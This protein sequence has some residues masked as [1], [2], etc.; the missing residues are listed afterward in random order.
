MKKR[1]A[2]QL[3]AI[4]PIIDYEK[5]YS[6]YHKRKNPFLLLKEKEKDLPQIKK[7]SNSNFISFD[8]NDNKTNNKL[9]APK[10]SLLRSNKI[11]NSIDLII[12]NKTNKLLY[13]KYCF[14]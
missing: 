10:L 5:F 14:I 12:M 11:T 8:N 1:I 2:L 13:Y 4:S 3:Q 6:N 7:D 9:I